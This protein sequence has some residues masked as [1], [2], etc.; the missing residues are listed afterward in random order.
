MIWM[1]MMWQFRNKCNAVAT[2]KWD[3]YVNL[4]MCTQHYVVRDNPQSGK[5]FDEMFK[6]TNKSK[7]VMPIK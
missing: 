7:V 3:N 1:N 6:S 4:G 5:T 2:R